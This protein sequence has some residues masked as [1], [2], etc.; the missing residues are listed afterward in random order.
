MA[1]DHTP[2]TPHFGARGESK[3]GAGQGYIM[4]SVQE[5]NKGR[6]EAERKGK[7]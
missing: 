7:K 5:G 1:W 4:K 2:V 6:M 3:L